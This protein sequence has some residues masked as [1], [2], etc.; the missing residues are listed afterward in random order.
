MKTDR[1]YAIYPCVGYQMT[2][3]SN[4]EHEIMDRKCHFKRPPE[5]IWPTRKE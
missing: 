2:G 1:W 4:I 3:V 5:E